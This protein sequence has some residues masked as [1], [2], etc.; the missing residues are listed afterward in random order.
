M[1][2]PSP[3][4]PAVPARVIEP[5]ALRPRDAA[6]ALGISERLLWDWTHTEGVPHV[7]IGNVVLY[8]VEVLKNWLAAKAGA[9]DES[10]N[11][12]P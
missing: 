1:T 9:A 8:P 2:R 7:R 6:L 11:D 12:V 3:F 10:V 5:L 4:S